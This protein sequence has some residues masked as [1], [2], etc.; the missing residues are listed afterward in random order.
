MISW[1]TF[2]RHKKK[3]SLRTKPTEQQRVAVVRSIIPECSGIKCYRW[4][5]KGTKKTSEILL[6]EILPRE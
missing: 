6:L 2:V 1:T 4:G 5:T 3:N